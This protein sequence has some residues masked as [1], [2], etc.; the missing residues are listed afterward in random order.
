MGQSECCEVC[1]DDCR[2]IEVEGEIYETIPA[3]LI[4]KAGFRCYTVS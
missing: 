1:E 3:E 4:I 2:T